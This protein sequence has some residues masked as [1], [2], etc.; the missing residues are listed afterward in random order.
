METRFENRYVRDENTAKEIY[1]YWFFKK[2]LMV[3]VYVVLAVYAISC[4]IGLG[5]DF[6]DAKEFIMPFI[7]AV[8]LPLLMIISYRSQVKTM[9]KRDKEMAK[10]GELI[11]EVSVNDNEFTVSSLESRSRILIDNA[12]YAFQTKSYIVVITK[13]RLMIILKKDSFTVGDTD[14]FIAFLKEKGIKVKGK[15]N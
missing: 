10:G 13:A 11:C 12:K 15:K 3:A 1:R 6:E 4:I 8:I 5:F 7:L 14:G 2:P 9:V